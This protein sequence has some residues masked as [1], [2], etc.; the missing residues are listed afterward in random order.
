LRADH[1]S[2][3]KEAL[4][5]L[6]TFH[7][8]NPGELVARNDDEKRNPLFENHTYHP[9][10]IINVMR[11][12]S[13]SE[14]SNLRDHVYALLGMTNLNHHTGDTVH[15]E[16]YALI[17]DYSKSVVQVIEELTLY[18]IRRDQSL[19][20]LCLNAP[21]GPNP[22]EPQLAMLPSWVP[23]LRFPNFGRSWLQN[24]EIIMTLDGY[25]R[26]DTP[27]PLR[28]YGSPLGRYLGVEQFERQ[29]LCGDTALYDAQSVWSS[30]DD[31][32][33][34][35]R[36][37]RISVPDNQLRLVGRS[38]GSIIFGREPAVVDVFRS[39]ENLANWNIF[40]EGH[41]NRSGVSA[42]LLQSASA[43]EVIEA[44]DSNL[45]SISEAIINKLKSE[46]DDSIIRLSETKV[47]I[48]IMHHRSAELLGSVSILVPTMARFEAESTIV[49]S[50]NLVIAQ[51]SYMVDLIA[52]IKELGEEFKHDK[53]LTSRHHRGPDNFPASCL[54][55]KGARSGVL[56]LLATG[57]PLPLLVRP[58]PSSLT[59]EFVGQTMPCQMTRE[60][61]FPSLVLHRLIMYLGAS[62][63]STE[64]YV[65]E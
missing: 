23:D 8:A 51:C 63:R 65:L 7:R 61:A 37:A 2:I 15:R 59:Y 60:D 32:V 26:L 21:Y 19:A 1:I 27:L 5:K 29:S 9:L 20:V 14:Y 53:S 13:G 40:H 4:R 57:S 24:P 10:D 46:Y 48:K 34:I 11:R 43:V 55:P 62:S 31:P 35:T 12:C 6:R 18:I 47:L 38:I 22:T 56:T 25:G 28:E 17:V 54:V 39:C 36:S 41:L 33:S 50:D 49:Q 45:Q 42:E 64:E 3:I 30:G 16:N 44:Q 58:R 52:Q